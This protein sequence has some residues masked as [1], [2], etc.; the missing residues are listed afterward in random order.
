MQTARVALAAGVGADFPQHC[1]DWLAECSI[2][3]EALLPCE[4]MTP[5][6]WQ[7]LEKDGR[8]HE[9][10]CGLSARSKAPPTLHL[11]TAG[12]CRATRYYFVALCPHVILSYPSSS[13]CRQIWRTPFNDQLVSM[14]RPR[15]DQLPPAYHTAKS[16]HVGVHPQD[17]SLPLLQEIGQAARSQQ[18]DQ[19]AS[20]MLRAAGLPA[21]CDV[22]GMQSTGLASCL[23]LF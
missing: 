16:Y 17:P 7:I 18:G 10:R 2:D 1:M 19:P 21:A 23:P 15:L 6:A 22:D 9:V 13:V 3:T 14:L 20:R 11:V 5:R 4:G 12:L 8:R